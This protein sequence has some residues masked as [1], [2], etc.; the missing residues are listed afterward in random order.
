MTI[1]IDRSLHTDGVID[2]SAWNLAV[3]VGFSVGRCDCGA[4]ASG[5]RIEAG[6]GLRW[7][8]LTCSECGENTYPVRREK[9]AA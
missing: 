8:T 9:V 5:Q 1:H 7:A 2:V 4:R 6:F 3:S